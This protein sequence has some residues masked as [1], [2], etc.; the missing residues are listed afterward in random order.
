M[1]Q[2]FTF[3]ELLLVIVVVGALLIWLLPQFTHTVQKQHQQ[4]INALDQARALQQT[5]NAQQQLRQRQLDGV[6]TL[7]K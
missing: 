1:K 6:G 3:I 5:L 4:Q 7:S 2:G